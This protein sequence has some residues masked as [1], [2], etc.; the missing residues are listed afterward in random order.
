MVGID[1]DKIVLN[2]I[3]DGFV[4]V[5][6]QNPTGKPISALIRSICLRVVAP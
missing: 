6:A 1:D 4:A 5:R 3:R 2:G